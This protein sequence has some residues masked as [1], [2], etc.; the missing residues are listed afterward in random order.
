MK[1][2]NLQL[3]IFSHLILVSIFS[4]LSTSVVYSQTTT[5]TSG[6]PWGANINCMSMV[7]TYPDFIYAGTDLGLFKTVD[8]GENWT[9][10]DF[11]DIKAR[12]VAVV[13]D[14]PQIVY[15]GSDSGLY[16]SED[17]GNT[18]TM[19]GLHE[20]S[21]NAIAVEPQNSLTLYV[22]T[23]GDTVG[24]FKSTD[25]GD[26]WQIKYSEGLNAV[27]VLLIDTENSSQ[28]YA[29]VDPDGSG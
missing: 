28:I 1:Y 7:I 24:I 13:S 18:W 25:G 15:V 19:K 29:G 17:G 11:P 12:A 27:W 14:D 10:T 9:K 4:S 23:G 5:W 3:R 16:K 2:T 20:A 6:G 21:I 22:G 8:G 26:T